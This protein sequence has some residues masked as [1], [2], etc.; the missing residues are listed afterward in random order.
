[1]SGDYLYELFDGA[2]SVTGGPQTSPK[3]TG[4]DAKTYTAFIYDQKA[5]GCEASTDITL[6]IPPA[7]LF[8]TTKTDVPCYG[9]SD[10]SITVILDPSMQ[11]YPYTYELYDSTATLVEGPQA[12]NVFTGLAANDYVV[13]VTSSRLC[14]NDEPV[15]IGE[16]DSIDVPA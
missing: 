8:T 10:G 13:R 1:G 12:S 5:T 16:P 2:T 4:L 11:N 14:V 6:S 3:F 7:V 9:G 15:T